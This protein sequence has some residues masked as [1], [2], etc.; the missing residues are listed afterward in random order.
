MWFWILYDLE[1]II[2]TTFALVKKM[3]EK[4]LHFFVL[5][6]EHCQYN[7]LTLYL[8][9][10][11]FDVV[12]KEKKAVPTIAPAATRNLQPPFLYPKFVLVSSVLNILP[13]FDVRVCGIPA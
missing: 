10:S 2:F 8:I 11:N 5:Q 4:I 12:S 7:F 13:K 3:L 6:R 1:I 9:S